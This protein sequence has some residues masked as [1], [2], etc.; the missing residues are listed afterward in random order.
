MAQSRF[1]IPIEPFSNTLM[2]ETELFCERN[3]LPLTVNYKECDLVIGNL[4][5]DLLL[6][7][8]LPRTT[9]YVSALTLL[10][11]YL[12]W[13]NSDFKWDD[14]GVCNAFKHCKL[15][16]RYFHE[17][18][19]MIN[20]QLE[21]VISNFTYRGNYNVWGCEIAADV[22]HIVNKGDYRIARYHELFGTDDRFDHAVK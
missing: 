7:W 8:T 11:E 12:S 16:G 1:V 18:I 4:I 10:E 15:S 14:V 9:T 19:E 2:I 6:N 13:F 3:N 20:Q 21:H 22:V 5:I 17:V